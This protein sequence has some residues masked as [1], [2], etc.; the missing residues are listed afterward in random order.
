LKRAISEPTI[1]SDIQLAFDTWRANGITAALVC[2]DPIFNEHRSDIRD[3]AKPV[4]G[5][6]IKTMH[7]WDDF[8][9]GHYG[10]YAYGT[11]LSECYKLAAKAAKDN[12]RHPI[13]CTSL[14]VW[15]GAAP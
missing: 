4:H 1:K 11:S 8:V 7:Q 2:A 10:D 6:K 9:S 13:A 14:P 12:V 15:L 3:A 5:I